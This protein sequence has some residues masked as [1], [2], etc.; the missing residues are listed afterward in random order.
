MRGQPALSAVH[1]PGDEDL[2][3]FRHRRQSVI[4]EIGALES[5]GRIVAGRLGYHPQRLEQ[6]GWA[7]LRVGSQPTSVQPLALEALL[8][9]SG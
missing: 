2:G 8:C 4:S 6:G 1:A 7:R 9:R 5:V 3:C